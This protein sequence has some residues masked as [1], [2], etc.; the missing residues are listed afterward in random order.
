VTGAEAARWLA[1]LDDEHDNMRAALRWTAETGAAELELRLAIALQPFWRLRGHAAEGCRW[2][3]AALERDGVPPP[4]RARALSAAGVLIDHRGDHEAGRRLLEQARALFA[5]LGDD[6]RL[7]RVT[8]ELGGISALL[9]EYDEAV[10]LFGETIPVFRERGDQRALLVTLANLASVVDLQGDHERAG[11]LA[12]E[13]LALA[14]EHGS[15]DQTG[16]LLHNVARSAMAR[17]RYDDAAAR[18]AES[19]AIG[20]E[21]GFRELIANCLAACAELA[22]AGG[23]RERAA[24]LL[25]AADALLEEIEAQ[26]ATEE[27]K[28][29]ERTL[30]L[31]DRELGAEALAALCAEG[32]RLPLGEAVAAATS[33]SAVRP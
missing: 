23:D 28:G 26:L 31:L 7:A 17:G 14:R 5:E 2:L 32:R 6:G 22:A 4:L 21:L 13:A 9:G 20:V 8:A 11:E 12:A 1:Q 33:R 25:G 30:A 16:I 10:V 15:G 27:R 24:V 3:Q 18:L 29:Y 19:I